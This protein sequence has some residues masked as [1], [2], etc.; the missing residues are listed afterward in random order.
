MDVAVRNLLLTELKKDKRFA[1]QQLDKLAEFYTHY[2]KQQLKSEGQGED[3]TQPQYWIAL[4]HSQPDEVNRELAK[5]IE[6]RLKQENWE[7]LFRIASS[8]EA[9]PEALVEFEAPLLNYARGMLSYTT[10]DLE[11]AAEEFSNLPRRELQVKIAGVNLSIPD[12]VED[13][14]IEVELT[15]LQRLLQIIS[16]SNSDK[17]VVE[18]FLQKN[19]G[20]LNEHLAEVLRLWAKNKLTQAQPNKAQSLATDISNFSILLTQFSLGSKASNI[21]IAITGYEIALTVFTREASP[22]NWAGIQA[23]LGN[24]YIDRILGNKA[25]NLEQAIAF[26]LAALQIFTRANFPQDWALTQIC[27]GEA[28]NN[29]I[30]GNKAENLEQAITSCLAA[31]QILTRDDFPKDWAGTQIN[32]GVAYINRILG[33]KADNLEMAIAAF[34]AALEVRTRSAFPYEWAATQNALGTAYRDRIRGD[35]AENLEMAIAAFEAALLERTRDRFPEDWALTQNN[36]GTAYIHR[37]RGDKAENLE[38]AIAAFS[39]ALEVYTRSAFPQN[40]AETQNNLGTAYCERILGDRAENLEMAIATYSAAL[41]VYTRESFPY[42]WALTQNNLGSAYRNRIRGEKAENLERAMAYCQEA[43]SIFTFEAFPGK[44][45]QTQN[46]IALVSRDRIRGERANNL[47]LAI[48]CFQEALQ[49]YTFDAFPYDWAQ[50]QNNLGTAY[51]ERILGVRAENLELAIAAF[52]DALRVRTR[53]ELPYDWAQTHNHLGTAYCNRILGERIENLEEAI[54]CFQNA[55]EIYTFDAFPQ[56]HAETLF[57]MGIA[58]QEAHEFTSAYNTFKSAIATVESLREE[59]ISG[60]ETKRK[61]AQEWN[62]LYCHMV[63]VCLNLDQLTEAL[64]YVERSKTRNLVELILNR[65]SKTIFSSDALN[66]LE[67]LRGEIAAVQ[68]KIQNGKGE[69]PQALGQYLQKLRQQRNELQDKYLPVGYGFNLEQFQ[70]N[71]DEQTAVIQWYI[72][73]FGWETFIITRQNIQ[74]FNISMLSNNHLDALT[75]FTNDYL[76]AYSNGKVAWK[77]TLASRLSHLTEILQIEYILQLIPKNCLRLVLIPHRSL[78]LFPL[79]ALPLA[80]REFLCEKFPKGV[81]YAPSCQLLQQLQYRERPNFKSIFAIQNPT[82][83]LVGT[84][85]EVENISSLF[86][87][88]QV[89]KNE[90]ATKI[91]INREKLK[92]INC[93]HLTNPIDNNYYP[94]EEFSLILANNERL[95]LSNILELD[96]SQC[97]LVT[98]S[99]G[100]TALRDITNF[101]DEYIN[102][103]SAFI[104]AGST[105]VVSSL[106]NI[107]D[108]STALLM[109]KFYQNLHAGNTVAIALNQAQIWL[110][111]LTRSELERWYKFTSQLEPTLR[112][113]QRMLM[114]EQ[115]NRLTELADNNQPFREPYYWAAFCCIGQ[116]ES[117]IS[118]DEENIL[119]FIYILQNQPEL[120]TTE[121]RADIL[122]LLATLAD[123]VEEISDAIALWYKTR[124]QILDAILNIPIENLDSSR[125]AEGRR[126][127][128]TDAEIKE[129]IENLLNQS[130]KSKQSDSSSS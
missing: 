113:G 40:W 25:E 45:A 128:I 52:H 115:L 9:I 63:E 57:N 98:L 23:L 53:D 48:A 126:T 42:H 103:S 80:N 94:L 117:Q 7:E 28:Y 81:S 66:Q 96:L 11:G 101:S 13:A 38:M 39:A 47:E 6:S 61:Q 20:K 34:A 22:K 114:R 71:L 2:L 112:E 111:N 33:D 124:P 121:D 17:Q 92:L 27:L 56:N 105:S 100:E 110:R 54:A 41:Q 14:L 127:S 86:P 90:S 50:T 70:T 120:L 37:I 107:D 77:D 102:L 83:N 3:L 58:Y 122:E 4:A 106:W 84:D 44:W 36:L 26:Y 93:L 19:I 10:G 60:E 65:D 51:C 109:I 75:N 67:Q 74:R 21:E 82:G 129:L 116:M 78:H 31:L 73:S 49:I 12:E 15:F 16:E 43:L 8:I 72:T 99:G 89:L 95:T 119:N 29:R 1:K 59:I 87:I 64:E 30:L 46:N 123:D 24:A 85:L 108:F 91:A 125:A 35:K 76:D 68:D 97:R 130:S 69:N 5:A 55:L 62:K 32:L 88:S 118:P 104:V 18:A 79:H